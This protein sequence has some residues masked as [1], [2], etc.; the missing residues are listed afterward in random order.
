MGL[1][2]PF[3]DVPPFRYLLLDDESDDETLGL[4]LDI[5]GLFVD[6]PGPEL[7]R[8][9]LSGCEPEG[10]LRD[11][12]DSPVPVRLGD[13]YVDAGDEPGQGWPLRDVTVLGRVDGLAD[14][15]VEARLHD[16]YQP[17]CCPPNVAEFRLWE[18]GGSAMG[19][20]SG[21]DGLF[22]QRLPAPSGP[23][24]LYGVEP[25]NKLR[26]LLGKG[27]PV[28]IGRTHVVFLDRQGNHFYPSWYTM[29]DVRSAVPSKAGDGLVDLVVANGV[30]DHPP[31]TAR[32]IWDMW[33]AGGPRE[34]NL[35]A[36][37]GLEGREAWLA[38]ALSRPRTG[39]EQG[40][41]QTFHI[42]GRFVTDEMGF[43]CALGEAVNG[44]GGYFGWNW[45]AIRDCLSGGFGARPPFTLVWHDSDVARAHLRLEAERAISRRDPFAEWVDLIRAHVTLELA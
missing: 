42:D 40:P 43:Y 12:L 23:M 31:R 28:P 37:Y 33:F 21:I 19:T 3:G 1:A 5:H 45:Q 8:I 7:V 34:K 41:G 4:C 6:P 39:P 30:S 32:S 26:R 20:C 38:A 22:V 9:T 10:V 24:T 11:A 25:R 15:A 27:T 2:L 18:D 29:L 17:P 44:P 13:V 35:W 14:V 16:F 36:G